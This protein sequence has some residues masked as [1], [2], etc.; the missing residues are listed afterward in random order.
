ML[1]GYQLPEIIL[2]LE[3]G[4]FSLYPENSWII[5]ESWHTLVYCCASNMLGWE[6]RWFQSVRQIKICTHTQVKQFLFVFVCVSQLCTQRKLVVTGVSF[7]PITICVTHV[8]LQ[9]PT[10]N[11]LSSLDRQVI[12]FMNLNMLIIQIVPINCY[13]TYYV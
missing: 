3:T 2:L 13:N 7:V 6:C 4:R 10:C 5:L 8:L 12:H 1:K 11:I 9:T